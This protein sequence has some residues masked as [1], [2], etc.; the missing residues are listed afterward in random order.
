MRKAKRRD[1]HRN[2]GKGLW[3]QGNGSSPQLWRCLSP[4][5]R[6]QCWEKDL[7]GKPLGSSP[8]GQKGPPPL[9]SRLERSGLFPAQRPWWA[10]RSHRVTAWAPEEAHLQPKN[11]SFLGCLPRHREG[12][13]QF[14]CPEQ[15]KGDGPAGPA[16]A[17]SALGLSAA[18]PQTLPTTFLRAR[19]VPA[20][21]SLQW[22]RHISTRVIFLK[23]NSDYVTFL[24]KIL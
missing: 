23:Y 5:H 19:S 7:P 16:E 22:D 6:T 8:C 20:V 14:L 3:K 15:G 2:V 17:P 13:R 1:C 21:T 9:Q 12:G 4:V 11:C 10:T 24:L 18:L